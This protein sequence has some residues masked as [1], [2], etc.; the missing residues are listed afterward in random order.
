MEYEQLKQYLQAELPINRKERFYTGTVLPSILFHQGFSNLF[1]FLKEIKGF[2]EDIS[3]STTQD[4]FLFYTEYN[5]KESAGKKSVGVEIETITGDTPDIIIEILQPRRALVVIEAKLFANLTQNDFERQMAAQKAAV[6]DNVKRK[7]DLH[8]SEV[9]HIA[10]TPE[11]LGFK[12][13][14]AYQVINW[15]F[16]LYNEDID[17]RSNYFVNFLRFALENYEALVCD[18]SGMASTV[19]GQATGF[20]IYQNGKTEDTLWVGRKGGKRT[21]EKDLK[22]GMWKEKLYVTNTQ[23][24]QGGQRGNWISSGEFA[25]IIDGATKGFRLIPNR[26]Y[27]CELLGDF[28]ENWEDRRSYSPI[29]IDGIEPSG[30]QAGILQLKFYHANYP[31]GVR[32]KTYKLKI[33]ASGDSFIIAESLDHTPARILHIYDIDSAWISRHFP[34]TNPNSEDIQEWLNRHS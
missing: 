30:T 22:N 10:L 17:V 19:E 3:Q 34:A 11:K 23:K 9:F 16:L 32:N 1:R 21:I 20:H 27:A 5:L 4:N 2:P 28:F 18:Q 31:E 7:Y 14:V 24:P 6:I 25:A 12:S 8:D 13:T 26:W 33:L 29:R 15:E